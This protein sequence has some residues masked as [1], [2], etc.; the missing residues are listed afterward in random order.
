MLPPDQRLFE[1][2]LQSAEFRN[3]A[4][5]GWWG[6]A[7]AEARPDD[8]TWPNVIVWI[9]AAPRPD[10]PDRYFFSLNCERYRGASPTGTFWDPAE[11]KTLENKKRPKGK[12]DSRFAKVFRTDWKS[13]V[14]IYHPY[15]RVAISDHAQW[16]TEQPH[17]IW[18]DKHT[19]VDWL[20]E[21]RGLLQSGDYVG[22]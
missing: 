17:L 3:G 7:E 8:L 20:E 11:K 14:A 18:D 15:D 16:R 6:V 5:K 12:S 10:A 21:F 4:E 1:A 19:I 2:D 22:V 13:S 9:A